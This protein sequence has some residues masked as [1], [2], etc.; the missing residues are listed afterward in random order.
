[1]LVLDHEQDNGAEERKAGHGR[2]WSF[3]LF[4]KRNGYPSG[5]QTLCCNHNQKKEMVRARSRRY[6]KITGF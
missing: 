3:Y 6:V 1:M 2:G 4:L 5:Y